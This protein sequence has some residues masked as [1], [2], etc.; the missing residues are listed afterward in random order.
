MIAEFILNIGLYHYLLLALCLFLIGV[1]GVIVSKNLIRVLICVE[2]MFNAVGINF[3]AFAKYYDGIKVDG[4]VFSIFIMG[5]CAVQ[6]A[7]GL[8]ILVA[9]FKYEHSINSESLEDLKG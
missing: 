3:V 9:F 8:A 1:V 7:I 5:V 6:L 4:M 2:I